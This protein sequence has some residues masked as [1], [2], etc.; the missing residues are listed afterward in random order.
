MKLA[1][2]LA[3]C[4]LEQPFINLLDIYIN[5]NY[6]YNG[7]NENN[8]GVFIQKCNLL[9]FSYYFVKVNNAF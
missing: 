2:C 9:H 4:L 7:N 5:N 1:M 3:A 8:D 6:K